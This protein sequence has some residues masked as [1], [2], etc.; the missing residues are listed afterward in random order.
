MSNPETMPVYELKAAIQ[1]IPVEQLRAYAYAFYQTEDQPDI[2]GAFVRED[3]KSVQSLTEG[4][5]ALFD[6]AEKRAQNNRSLDDLLE[7]IA[8]RHL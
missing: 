5:R 8:L 2:E 7:D 4:N 1:A 3:G 6:E